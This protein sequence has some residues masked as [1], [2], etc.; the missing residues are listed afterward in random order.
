MSAAAM[1]T[2]TVVLFSASLM[3]AAAVVPECGGVPAF[4]GAANYKLVAKS[5]GDFTTVQAAI[6]SVPPQNNQWFKI[7]IKPGTYVEQ[8]TIPLE[9]PCIFLEGKERRTTVIEFSAH[10]QTDSSSTFCSSPPNIVVKGITF[11]NTF[12]QRFPL[13]RAFGDNITTLLVPALAARIYGDKSAFYDC[14]FI[15]V[16]DTLWDAQGR[17]YYLNCYIEGAIDF[18]FGNGQSFYENTQINVTGGGYITAQ[19]RTGSNDPSGFVFY[20]G[21]VVG[22]ATG[23]RVFLSRAYGPFSR[24]IFHSTYLNSVIEPLGWN[25]WR[26]VGKEGNFEYAEV[27]C[28]GPGLDMSKRVPWEKKIPAD[29]SELNQFSR[30]AFIDQDGWIDRQPTK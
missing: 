6:D 24:V 3:E 18:I 23:I 26:F 30:Q 19:R 17:H 29:S 28:S 15:G 16:Q 2:L 21:Q 8:V 22:A 13:P 12:E 5:G 4:W 7:H 20:G 27:N 25:A 10:A 14:A 11:K 9:K 1:L